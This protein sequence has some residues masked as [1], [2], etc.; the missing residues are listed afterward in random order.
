MDVNVETLLKNKPNKD[1]FFD[2]V[3]VS[4]DFWKGLCEDQNDLVRKQREEFQNLIPDDN[5]YKTPFS[6]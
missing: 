5:L 2:S 4:K 1:K 3:K 6:L